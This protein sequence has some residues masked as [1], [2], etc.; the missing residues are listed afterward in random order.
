MLLGIIWKLKIK[1]WKF[2]VAVFLFGLIIVFFAGYANKVYAQAK[3]LQCAPGMATVNNNLTVCGDLTVNNKATVTNDLTVNKDIF[4]ASGSQKI[5]LGSDAASPY[6]ANNIEGILFKSNGNDNFLWQSPSG[7]PESNAMILMA[8]GGLP[9]NNN[10]NLQVFG[11]VSSY[12]LHTMGIHLDM[13]GGLGSAAPWQNILKIT[14]SDNTGSGFGAAVFHGANTWRANT[15]DN[16]IFSGLTNAQ[17]I[18]TIG[19]TIN[20]A[21]G[22]VG[23]A[24]VN[25][26]IT[27]AIGDNDT[28]LKWIS[29]G[30]IAVYTDNAE[31]VRIDSNG[32]VGIG[33]IT[34]GVKLEVAGQ[35]KITGGTPALGKVLTSDASGLASWES[36][37]GAVESDPYIGTVNDGQWCTGDATG[38][39]N[40]TTSAPAF[41]ETDTLD[42][43]TAR[44]NTTTNS[45]TVSNATI[46]GDIINNNWKI[47]ARGSDWAE[48]AVITLNSAGSSF[49]VDDGFNDQRVNTAIFSWPDGSV[50]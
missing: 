4:A 16:L 11:Q 14:N 35:I 40:C 24:T 27:L 48:E 13:Q 29:D 9:T 28:G 30:N 26:Q 31:R 32:N 10:F 8:G 17:D 37:P 23:V 25:P 34:P 15:D 7:S 49:N 39:V 45:I 36:V 2:P 6:I 43:V 12:Q 22:N 20:T 46:G 1:N 18:G 50:N 47:L 3:V 42:T 41:S 19:L 21:S 38:T 5:Y 44:G 33:T